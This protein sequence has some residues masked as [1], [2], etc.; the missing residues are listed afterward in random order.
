MFNDEFYTHI[1]YFY[2][3]ESLLNLETQFLYQN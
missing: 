1:F 3:F 2:A